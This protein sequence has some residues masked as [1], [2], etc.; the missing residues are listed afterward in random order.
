[1]SDLFDVLPPRLTMGRIATETSLTSTGTGS[2]R[3]TV[4]SWIVKQ[5]G[6]MSGEK[7]A[8]ELKVEGETMII[9][10]SPASEGNNQ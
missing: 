3:T 5:F 9:Q 6:L 1:M 10:V 8:W 2:L 7:I 4:P